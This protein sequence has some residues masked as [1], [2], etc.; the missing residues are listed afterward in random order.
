MNNREKNEM[1]LERIEMHYLNDIP[2]FL[3]DYQPQHYRADEV[4]PV[5]VAEIPEHL[6][7]VPRVIGVQVAWK[8]EDSLMRCARRCADA[9]HHD[10]EVDLWKALA[11]PDHWD[12]AQRRTPVVPW[13][14]P[15]ARPA[16]DLRDGHG[17]HAWMGV[18]AA[19]TLLRHPTVAPHLGGGG[20]MIQQSFGTNLKTNFT[21]DGF[22]GDPLPT[23]HVVSAKTL[24]G[25]TL[26]TRGAGVGALVPVLDPVVFVAPGSGRTW[27]QP[28]ADGCGWALEEFAIEGF[29]PEDLSLLVCTMVEAVELPTVGGV[30]EV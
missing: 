18:L 2:H 15:D 17:E 20:E 12:P 7:P 1:A 27:R 9:I 28:Q 14:Q 6:E 11:S 3:D 16:D 19:E 5:E 26:P 25:G 10:R 8:A 13:R 29:D 23:V 30:L 21:L 4:V 24:H 22:P